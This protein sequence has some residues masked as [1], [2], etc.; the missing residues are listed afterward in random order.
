MTF[1]T[2]GLKN[3][4][5]GLS[6]FTATRRWSIK[7]FPRDWINLFPGHPKLNTRRCSSLYGYWPHVRFRIGGEYLSSTQPVFL[8][9][10]FIHYITPP[11]LE[12]ESYVTLASLPR[13]RRVK[14]TSGAYALLC[15]LF[16][17]LVARNSLTGSGLT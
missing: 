2:R 14:H 10:G 4:S 12:Q 7:R 5:G 8:G 15:C 17:S 1:C 13:S 11:L 6:F 3:L 16:R 9:K